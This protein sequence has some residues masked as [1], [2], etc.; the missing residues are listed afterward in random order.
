MPQY[1]T[2]K[3][4]IE[5]II[6]EK[7]ILFNDNISNTIYN[8]SNTT[9]HISETFNHLRDILK[10][11]A[12]P[13]EWCFTYLNRSLVL[14]NLDSNYEIIKKNIT[15]NN[16]LNLKVWFLK[17]YFIYIISCIR[18]FHKPTSISK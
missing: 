6:V 14:G 10:N 8:I 12:L 16:D 18:L 3:K 15:S 9:D 13:D 7:M 5:R 11:M 4:P 17:L 2:R 1:L